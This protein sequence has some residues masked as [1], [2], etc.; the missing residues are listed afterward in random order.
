MDIRSLFLHGGF[1]LPDWRITRKCLVVLLIMK[2]RHPA[3]REVLSETL[4]FLAKML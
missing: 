1:R 3:A 2:I 4:D